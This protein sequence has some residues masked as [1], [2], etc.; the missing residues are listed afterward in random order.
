VAGFDIA[1]RG[2]GVNDPFLIVLSPIRNGHVSLLWRIDNLEL[3]WNTGFS[4]RILRRPI[5]GT[6][7]SDLNSR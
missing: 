7:F 2:P 5:I 4:K 1:D 3:F 6:P